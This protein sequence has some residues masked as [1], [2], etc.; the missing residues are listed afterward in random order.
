MGNL[1]HVVAAG[2]TFDDI[3][4]T[5]NSFSIRVIFAA[6]IVLI[7]LLLIATR[8]NKQ[9]ARKHFKKPLFIAIAATVIIPS[10]LLMGSTVYINTIADSKGPVHWHTDVE[11]WVCGQE[12]ELRDPYQFLSNKIGTASYHEHDDKRMHLEGVVID[13]QVDASLDKF[14]QV[15]GGSITSTSLV[16]PTNEQ[17]FENDRDGDVP[18]GDRSIVE[19]Y[20]QHDANGRAVVS[21][22]NEDRCGSFEMERGELQAFVIRA[23]KHGDTYTQIKLDNP[24]DYIMRD[25][26]TVPP[27]DCL[28][29][30]FESPR[31]R[32][33]HLCQQYGVRD[34]K[35]CTEFGVNPFSPELCKLREV[36]SDMTGGRE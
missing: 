24:A 5:V 27:G 26:S 10:L 30:D 3:E 23:D 35:R 36:P 17:I 2:T 34:L 16:I 4:G 1:F 21:V 19:S 33:T 11:F 29:I 9:K 20:K 22:K 8:V 12:I 28:I 14:M 7:I 25:E 15:I 32:T 13:R 31:D 18:Y 6:T